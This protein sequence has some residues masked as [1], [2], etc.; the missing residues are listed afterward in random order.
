MLKVPGDPI[1]FFFPF[2]FDISAGTQNE[3]LMT[4]KLASYSLLLAIW[5]RRK[6]ERSIVA[7]NS[8]RSSDTNGEGEEK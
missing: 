5:E 6:K 7:T 2:P 1:L 4:S 8:A 3:T